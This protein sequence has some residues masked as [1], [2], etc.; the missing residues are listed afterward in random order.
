MRRI[1]LI[2]VSKRER[3]KGMLKQRVQRKSSDLDSMWKTFVNIKAE[4]STTYSCV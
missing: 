2:L 4:E 3:G 1:R